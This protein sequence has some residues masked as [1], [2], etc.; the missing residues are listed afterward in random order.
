MVRVEQL[1]VIK[2]RKLLQITR[3][4]YPIL[5]RLVRDVIDG[6]VELLETGNSGRRVTTC[7]DGHTIVGD[8]DL[9]VGGER[10]RGL[11]NR[12]KAECRTLPLS[13]IEC[14]RWLDELYVFV[15]VR[16]QTI[17]GRAHEDVAVLSVLPYVELL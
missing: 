12:G 13:T 6:I 16:R 15:E 2:I 10:G 3:D 1:Q 4:R 9:C 5:V 14:R 8:G 11:W 17:L 7:I